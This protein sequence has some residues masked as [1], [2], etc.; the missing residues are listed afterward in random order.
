MYKLLPD[1]S[2]V[3][4][5]LEEA[6]AWQAAHTHSVTPTVDVLV[7]LPSPRRNLAER[8][9]W[10]QMQLQ[11]AGSR[12]LLTTTLREGLGVH[13]PVLS[14]LL[15]A[16]R[17]KGVV[18]SRTEGRKLRWFIDPVGAI[19]ENNHYVRLAPASLARVCDSA[20]APC[21]ATQVAAEAQ[22]TSDEQPPP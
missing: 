5:S 20:S 15:A 3:T 19:L 14:R 9:Q 10:L 16:L 12:G 22:Q 2:I 17:R 1:G 13:A 8:L 4:D 18:Y 11:A 21:P 7:N 6:L